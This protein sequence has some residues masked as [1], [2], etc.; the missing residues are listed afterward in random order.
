[1]RIWGDFM[2]NRPNF[3]DELPCLTS[4]RYLTPSDYVYTMPEILYLLKVMNKSIKRLK[5]PKSLLH[6]AYSQY[7]A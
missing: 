7:K 5:N 4:I 1:M 6:K 2:R 3:M